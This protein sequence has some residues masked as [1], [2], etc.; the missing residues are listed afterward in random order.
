[1]LTS[2]ESVHQTTRPGNAILLNGVWLAANREI[3]VPG[4]GAAPMPTLRGC[5]QAGHHWI[6]MNIVD[7]LLEVVLVADV[8]VP[9]LAVPDGGARPI[10]AKPP[11]IA[12]FARSKLLPRCHDL[13]DC[14]SIHWLEKG[15]H[16]IRHYHPCQQAVP[17]RIKA[18]QRSLHYGGDGWLA[19]NARAVARVDPRV[20]PL[21]AFDIPLLGGKSLQF[22]FPSQQDGL[23]EAVREMKGH[24][25]R[26]VGTFKVRKVSTAVPRC[27]GNAILMNGV[28]VAANRE[29]GV[30]GIVLTVVHWI[31]GVELIRV[32][33]F[34][35]NQEIA[36]PERPH[37]CARSRRRSRSR[38]LRVR[39]AARSN[40]A[41]ASSNRPSF[42]RRSPRTLGKR[43]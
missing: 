37:A 23:R 38:A 39:E 8:T 28:L 1:M 22:G 16:V 25:L 36:V 12:N 4:V 34:Y 2:Q 5:D 31:A 33:I 24:M 42:F 30:P 10:A 9:I 41:R 19:Q 3:G 11:V 20:H 13:R 6:E 15:M 7:C 35:A 43:W 32:Y 40:S 27:P 26:Y 29:I 21:A 17:L 18:Q 14:P